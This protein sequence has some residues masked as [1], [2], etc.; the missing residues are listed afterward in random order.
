MTFDDE[1]SSIRNTVVDVNR[2][3]NNMGKTYL[4]MAVECKSKQIISFLLF[5]TKSD[6]N[7]LTRDSEM[8]AL[9]IAV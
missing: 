5:D 4:H 2:L 1:S 6:P 7:I 3:M 8:G 9:H